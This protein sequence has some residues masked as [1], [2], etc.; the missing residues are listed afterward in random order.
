MYSPYSYALY[1]YYS[2]ITHKQ[3]NYYYYI[4]FKNKEN[5]KKKKMKQPFSGTLKRTYINIIRLIRLA[6]CGYI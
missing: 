3:V 4:Y 2:F 1:L 6:K 5:E